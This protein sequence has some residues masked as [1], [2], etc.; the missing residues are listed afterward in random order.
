M[1]LIVPPG[2]ASV[3]LKFQVP[4]QSGEVISTFGIRGGISP[5][6]PDVVDAVVSGFTANVLPILCEATYCPEATWEANVLGVMIE[7]TTPVDS[8]GLLEGD[9]MPPNNAWLVRKLTGFVGRTNRGRMYLPGLEEGLV[10]TSGVIAGGTV[11]DMNAGLADWLTAVAAADV[12][13]VVFHDSEG[14]GAADDPTVIT[15]LVAQAKIATQ[16]TRL[17]D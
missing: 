15:Q 1:S 16:R 7:G 8:S 3:A 6:W 17:R 4:G 12:D 11:T 9:Q 14:A 5:D 13:L 10:N 2:Y